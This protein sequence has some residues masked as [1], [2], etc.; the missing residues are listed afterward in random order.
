MFYRKLN[1]KIKKLQKRCLGIVYK[2]N[3]S[4]FEELLATDN[5]VLAHDRNIQGFPTE[6]YKIMNEHSPV[7]MKEYKLITQQTKESFIQGL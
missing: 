3:T 2:D 6:L 4:S 5:F 1:N 7:I